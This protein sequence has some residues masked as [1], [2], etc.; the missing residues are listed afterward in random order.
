MSRG[1]G[2]TELLEP[3]PTRKLIVAGDTASWWG[4]D[5]GTTRVAI[6][7][8]TPEG[9]RGVRTVLVPTRDGGERLSITYDLTRAA[10]IELCNLGLAPG[11][12]VVEQPSGKQP[13]PPLSYAV[14]AT[15]AALFAGC[16]R[17]DFRP[18]VET[19]ASSRWKAVACG[20]GDL[21]KP[22]GAGE[23]PV[24]TWARQNGYRG[25]SYDEADAWSIAEFAR[26]TFALEVR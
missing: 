16:A 17:F 21:Y 18:V 8:V 15:M 14:G 25:S 19:V 4:V 10:T 23:Y 12:I 6:A 11:V 3:T 9:D 13:N 7:T 20:R 2:Q 26:R 22:K 5:P 1:L 24:L